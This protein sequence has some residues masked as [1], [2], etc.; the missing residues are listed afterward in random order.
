MAVS[1]EETPGIEQI[2]GYPGDDASVRQEKV[3]VQKDGSIVNG[4]SVKSAAG[5]KSV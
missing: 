5:L 2:S 1:N 3:C 4:A